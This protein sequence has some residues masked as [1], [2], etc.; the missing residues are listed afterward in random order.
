LEFDGAAWEVFF[1]FGAEIVFLVFAE[2]AS[3]LH[4]FDQ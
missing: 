4:I 1:E 3:S 2:V